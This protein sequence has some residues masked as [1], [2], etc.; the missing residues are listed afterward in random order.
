MKLDQAV[1]K[2]MQEASRVPELVIK[3]KMMHIKAKK[4]EF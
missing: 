4:N 2:M 1:Q 3:D